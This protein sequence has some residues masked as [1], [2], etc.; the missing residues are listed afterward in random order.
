MYGVF[1]LIAEQRRR[2]RGADDMPFAGDEACA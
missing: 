2:I 1:R